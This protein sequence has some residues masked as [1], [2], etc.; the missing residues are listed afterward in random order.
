MNTTLIEARNLVTE[1]LKH[2][3]HSI[4][5]SFASIRA[6]CINMVNACE[7]LETEG[8]DGDQS[9]VETMVNVAPFV[10]NFDIHGNWVGSVANENGFTN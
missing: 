10:F 9:I 8:D 7:I 4:P 6:F 5:S 1:Y 2:A 3:N